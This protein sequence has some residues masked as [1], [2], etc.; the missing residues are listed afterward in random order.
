MSALVL[1]THALIWYLEKSP[2]LSGAAHAAIKAAV[3]SGALLH[4]SAISLAEIVYLEEKG[5]IAAG[6]FL[7]VVGE[8]GRSGSALAEVA[9]NSII[10]EAMT[11]IPR[12]I[13]PDL[14]DR[15][16]AETALHLG[17]P[18]VTADLRIRSANLP[19]IW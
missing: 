1:D 4:V 13:V 11:R 5:R 12:D 16:L 17:V 3:G 7:R 10:A 2:R 9:F 19:T 18:L 8:I 6:T 14:P 15:I